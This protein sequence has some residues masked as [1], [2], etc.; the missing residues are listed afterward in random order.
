MPLIYY[1]LIPKLCLGMPLQAKLSLAS[2]SVPKYNLGTRDNRTM[3][4]IQSPTRP[5]SNPGILPLA[6]PLHDQVEKLVRFL[7]VI[8]PQLFDRFQGGTAVA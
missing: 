1:R 6:S 8:A 7:R 3:T 4:A 5:G 2:I